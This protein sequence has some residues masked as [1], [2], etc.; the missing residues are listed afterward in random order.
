M[1]ERKK[2]R[3]GW[4]EEIGTEGKRRKGKERIRSKGKGSEGREMEGKG[5]EG[6]K[7]EGEGRVG[8]EGERSVVL[9][10]EHY[11]K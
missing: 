6:K 2:E 11:G 4:Q 5:T 3:K 8:S 1:K 9:Y 7:R 10:F